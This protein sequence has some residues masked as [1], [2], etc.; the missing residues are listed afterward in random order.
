MGL[1]TWFLEQKLGRVEA[2]LK[3]L[4]F[5]QRKL[6][7]ELADLDARRKRGMAEAE[8][9]SRHDA[10]D[11]KKREVTERVNALSAEEAALKAELKAARAASRS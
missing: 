6:R 3:R 2:K 5:R 8:Y 7:D 1:R 9:R 10:L 11:A 4:H